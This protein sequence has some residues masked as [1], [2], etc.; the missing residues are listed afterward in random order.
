[1]I[2]RRSAKR[3]QD[4]I[5][6]FP[7]VALL[8]PRQVGKTTLARTLAGIAETVYLDLENPHDLEKLGDARGYLEGQSGKL[9]ILD[10]VQ[11]AP[12]LFRTLRGLIDDGILAGRTSGRFLLLGSASIDLLRQSGESLA[13]RI[14]YAE[15]AP[16]D[17]LEIDPGHASPL[18]IRGGFPRS[19]LAANDRQSAAWR[20][21]FI[22]TNLERDIPQLGPRIPAETLRRFWTMLAHSQGALLNAAQLARSLAVDGKTVAKYLDLMV[23]L[24]LVRRLPPFH[25]NAGKRLVKSPKTYVRDSGILHALLRLDTE[26]AVLGHPVCGASWEGF[27]I[28]N[29]LRVAPDRTEASFYRTSSGAEIDL[30]L[31]LPDNRTWAIKIK[32]GGVPKIEKGFHVALEDI[33]PDKAFVVYSGD[34]RYTKGKGIE[35]I[36]VREMAEALAGLS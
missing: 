31:E 6:Q 7:A 36:G 26:D 32:R 8:G 14:A 24:L 1:M 22:R 4:L 5:R 10:E 15:L 20:E 9:V 19:F 35:A 21:N 25:A 17:V 13:G 29:L 27:V 23:D 2:A 34:D 30:L 18:W 12:G 28:E 11:R 3:L 16:L 33:R